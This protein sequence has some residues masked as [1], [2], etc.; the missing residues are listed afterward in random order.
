MYSP[1]RHAIFA[2][3]VYDEMDQPLE[4]TYVGDTPCYVIV[5]AGFRRH[6]EADKIDRQ[7][8]AMLHEQIMNNREVVTESMLAL[9]GKDDLFTKAMVDA[10]LKNIDENITKLIEQGLPEG[11]RSWLG[12]LG[13]RIVVNV[14]G[15]VVRM[16]SPGIVAEE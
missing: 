14:H 6:V 8:L 16:D 2:G 4:T 15:E 13:F 12:L 9:L 11:V 10:S 3:L 7:V 1:L 5:D